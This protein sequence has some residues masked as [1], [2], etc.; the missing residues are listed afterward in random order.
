M[1]AGLVVKALPCCVKWASEMHWRLTSEQGHLE[2][3]TL[4]QQEVGLVF[5]PTQVLAVPFLHR[6]GSKLSSQSCSVD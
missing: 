1:D 4:R 2:E 5:I 6:L 3:L